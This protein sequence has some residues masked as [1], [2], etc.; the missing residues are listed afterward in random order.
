MSVSRRTVS[1]LFC[2]VV[3]SAPLGERLDA[4]AL[5]ELMD[6]YF[7]DVRAALERHGG[8]VEKFI[9]DAV[10]G[11]FGI[12][13][14]HEDDA[15]RAV[16]AAAE[17]R[18]V[19]ARLN[20]DVEREF[21]VGL[22]VRIGVATGEVVAGDPTAGHAFATGQPVVLAQ[23]L[24]AAARPGEILIAEETHRHAGAALVAEPVEE[25]QLKGKAES[26]SAWRLLGVISGAEAV[27][28][29]FDT[30]LVGRTAELAQ[31]RAAF[32]DAR[33][34]G[35]ARLVTI[36]GAP[37]V[38]K[39]R[40]LHELETLLGGAARVLTGR[41]LH[42]GE[43]ITYWPVRE[44]V[45]RAFGLTGREQ[46]PEVA[47]RLLA[48]LEG[49]DDAELVVERIAAILD[50]GAEPR[51][52]AEA[53]WGVRRLLES[54]ARETPLVVVF[55]DIHWA[56][57]TFLDLVEYLATRTAAPVLLA[58]VARPELLDI[59]PS[60][61]L[62]GGTA[63]TIALHPL[64]NE[65]S[66]RLATGLGVPG[67]ALGR[68]IE[69]AEGNP[70][71]LEEFARMVL[72][73]QLEP[74]AVPPT[75]Q[76]LL[77]ARVDRLAA[78]EREM[79]QHASVLGKT[80][81]WRA[82]A[83]LAP[84]AADASQLQTLVRKRLIEPERVAPAGE[85]AFRFGHIL[86]REAAYGALP[87]RLRA[88]LHERHADWVERNEGDRLADVDEIVGY[89]L[90][91][92]ALS[93][94][95]VS[96]TDPR[97]AALATRAGTRLA[98]AG[99][100]AFA[101]DDVPAA[102]SLLARANALLGESTGGELLLELG[103]AL[104]KTGEF[105][106]AE[107]A[108]ARAAQSPDRRL[109]LRAEIELQTVRSFVEPAGAAEENARVA[110]QAIPELERL[111][112][113][114]GLAKAWRLL[115]EAHVMASR[116]EA[117][118]EALERALTHARRVPEARR[119]A[120]TI[121]MLLGQAL[122]YGP[123]PAP[124]AIA[125]CRELLRDAESDAGLRAGVTA[126]LAGL[127]AM[128][129]DF[130]QARALYAQ[131]TALLDDLGLRFRRAVRTLVGAEIEQLAGDL[132]AAERE[133]RNGYQTLET[134]GERGVRAVLAAFLADVLCE[135]GEDDEAERFAG[136]AAEIVEPSDLV[137]H[138]LERAVRARVLARRGDEAAEALAREAVELAA[139]SDFPGLRARTLLALAEV[140]PGEAE[141]LVA[142]AR[143]LY[144]RKGNLAAADSLRARPA[145]S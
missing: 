139:R 47:A 71:F 89:H 6:R 83:D 90:E 18:E 114:Y 115:S 58:C 41:C 77:A 126:T 120:S 29:R 116:W 24:E 128:Q 9:G 138:A 15:L 82:L 85:D 101:R 30:P 143:S 86:I 3:G 129:G 54:L 132:P 125:R 63:R 107:D 131:S 144:E 45:Q 1:V 49:V 48:G 12:P 75:I 39:S 108:F 111:G 34:D 14:L 136:I 96:P 123:T 110:E 91:V 8:T 31:L 2:D 40:L 56:E 122:H 140:V 135:R 26:V 35:T 104:A 102:A 141:A 37:G 57:P 119:D 134:I 79:L 137:P 13:S 112:D 28:R 23:R 60:W 92:A 51:P 38:G 65:E 117:R 70:L 27:P 98:E 124:V 118:A 105:G 53:F 81:S 25:L 21:G 69:A 32:D 10:M 66:R 99:R 73:G 109:Q 130:E 17:L 42:Y 68:V 80:F 5:R 7:G 72:D 62:A 88:A 11:V 67:Q 76:A 16:R 97:A 59:R 145:V 133:L 93:L 74:E 19:V 100:R 20:A 127:T 87:K 61:P 103:N 121:A 113:D 50:P 4:E 36:A 142:E 55:E 78:A 33:A 52:P 44:L 64:G 46:E 22:R 84:G 43:G 106:R 95:D 94:R